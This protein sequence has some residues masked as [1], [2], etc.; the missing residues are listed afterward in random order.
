[1]NNDK[2]ILEDLRT[3]KSQKEKIIDNL[4]IDIKS[5]E[6][7]NKDNKEKIET[8]NLEVENLKDEI[9]NLLNNKQ[10]ASSK[11]STLNAN[12]EN[13]NLRKD[14]IDL[15]IREIKSNNYQLLSST[16]YPY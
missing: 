5:I 9:I 7:N 2:I 16:T 14:T 4:N 11:L 3:Q 13:I 12:I 8:I 6:S 10:E 15:D 1:M